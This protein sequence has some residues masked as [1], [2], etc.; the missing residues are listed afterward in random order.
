MA[1]HYSLVDSP[2]FHDDVIKRKASALVTRLS[3]VLY[4]LFVPA[5]QEPACFEAWGQDNHTYERRR[6]RF[7]GSF[8]EALEFKAKALL[9]GKEFGLAV[10]KPNTKDN[11]YRHLATLYIY[12]PQKPHVTIEAS[13]HILGDGSLD[14]TFKL[15]I[16]LSDIEERYVQPRGDKG[17]PNRKSLAYE[18]NHDTCRPEPVKLAKSADQ[19]VYRF[20]CLICK[21]WGYWMKPGKD[22]KQGIFVSPK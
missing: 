4:P 16:A 12:T 7:E 8:V 11:N 5:D 20:T 19:V 15:N 3:R 2:R 9:S 17:F 18:K 14:D 6:A 13:E 10:N 21:T 1:A 22:I